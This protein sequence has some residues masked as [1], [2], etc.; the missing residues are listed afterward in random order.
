MKYE[1]KLASLISFVFAIIAIHI[2][3]LTFTSGKLVYSIVAAIDSLIAV[4][5]GIRTDET[6][7]HA[8]VVIGI[9]CI[10]YLVVRSIV[11]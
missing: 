4:I 2:I 5:V 1:K 7:G 9:V 11:I 6:I 3:V 8:A 10:L